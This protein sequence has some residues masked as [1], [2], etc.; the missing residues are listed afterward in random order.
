MNPTKKYL[1]KNFKCNVCNSL[2][3]SKNSY[4]YHL[5]TK[6][7]KKKLEL[8]E[9]NKSIYIFDLKFSKK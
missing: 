1:L 4:L 9:F 3:C 8:L 2:S 7:H 6:K 5:T